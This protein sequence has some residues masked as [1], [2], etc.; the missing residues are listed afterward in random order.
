MSRLLTVIITY[1]DP[2]CG[3]AF[4]ALVDHL[5]RDFDVMLQ[6][7]VT[8]DPSLHLSIKPVSVALGGGHRDALYKVLQDLFSVP[9]ESVYVLSML[10]GNAAE[11]YRKVKDLVQNM[12]PPLEHHVVT[13]LSNYQDVGLVI[14]N[15]VRRVVEFAR[16]M[17]SNG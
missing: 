1:D 2:D 4:D 17:A 11:E 16:L 10:K 7:S 6:R 9:R 14:R 15:L 3:G 5:Q 8:S 13:H 12:T